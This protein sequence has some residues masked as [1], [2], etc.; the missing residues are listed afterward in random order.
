MLFGVLHE[1]PA[2]HEAWNV[3]HVIMAIQLGLAVALGIFYLTPPGLELMVGI[4]QSLNPGL[5]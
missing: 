5:L 4:A 2:A 3:T 1:G